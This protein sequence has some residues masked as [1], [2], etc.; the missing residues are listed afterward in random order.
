MMGFFIGFL[1]GAALGPCCCVVAAL[2]MARRDERL[3]D[4]RPDKYRLW[5]DV[6]IA[7]RP[8]ANQPHANQRRKA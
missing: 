8:I 1:F 3:D 2:I 6:P 4:F 5:E 7:Q